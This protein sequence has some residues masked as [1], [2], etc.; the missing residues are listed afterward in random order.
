MKT[1][2]ILTLVLALCMVLALGVPALASSEASGEA[3]SGGTSAPSVDYQSWEVLSDNAAIVIENGEV[4]VADDADEM[5]EG[6]IT[7]TEI[8][9]TYVYY[10][11]IGAWNKTETLADGGVAGQSGILINNQSDSDAADDVITIGGE[12]LL[13]SVESDYSAIADREFNTVIILDNE[14]KGEENPSAQTLTASLTRSKTW[15][16]P[17]APSPAWACTWRPIRSISPTP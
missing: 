13:Y 17:T 12:E 11:E 1:K 9:G 15:T 5:T 10:S 14:D 2:R 7:A 8:S 16:T 3:S 4:T 6:T